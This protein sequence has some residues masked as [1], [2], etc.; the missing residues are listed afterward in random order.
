MSDKIKPRLIDLLPIK[1]YNQHDDKLEG[2]Y[3]LCDDVET[4][5]KKLTHPDVLAQLM[6]GA[7]FGNISME[8]LIES[9]NKVKL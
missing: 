3:F 8:K 2:E 6:K 5:L 4:F 1:K 7:M 9:I